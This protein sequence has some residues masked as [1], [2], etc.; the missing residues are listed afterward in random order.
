MTYPFVCDVPDGV[1]GFII[2]PSFECDVEI[3]TTWSGGEPTFHCT[4]VLVDGRSLRHGSK[5][6]HDLYTTI[7]QLAEAE[8][9]AGGPLWTRLSADTGISFSG[10]AGS[11]DAG[12]VAA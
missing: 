2:I 5:L 12:W 4:D 6:S 10:H 9:D 11:P 7:S 8:I 3:E 1:Y